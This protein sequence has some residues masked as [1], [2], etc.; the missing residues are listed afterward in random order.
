[1]KKLRIV[2]IVL[3]LVLLLAACGG[4]T[5]GDEETAK[6]A[7]ATDALT[8]EPTDAPTPTDV[9][10]PSPV[11]TA[12]PSI[13]EGTNVAL[14]ADV[15]TTTSTG[16]THV[17][18][19]WSYE[20]LN[21]GVIEATAEST[22]WS[23]MV[24]E[25]HEEPETEQ[26]IEFELFTYTYINKVILYPSRN[27]TFFPVDFKIQVSTNGSKFTDVAEVTGCELSVTKTGEPV[28]LEFDTVMAKYVRVY[29]SKYCETPDETD[30]YLCQMAEIEILAAAAPEV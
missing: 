21:D 14:T 27:G 22:G 13:A 12:D 19:G 18:W 6:P 30:G 9:P 3:A 26:W 24:S 4:G 20:F 10:T 25:N 28:T 23:S 7:G 16:Q 8:S 2:S 11:P 15:D 29:I 1:M 5:T 17:Q